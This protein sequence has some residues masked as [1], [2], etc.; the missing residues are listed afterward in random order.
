MLRPLGKRDAVAAVIIFVLTVA[1]TYLTF[2][3]RVTYWNETELKLLRQQVESMR[4]VYVSDR[5][6]LR[7]EL[8]EVERTL[9][10]QPSATTTIIRRP[11]VVEQWQINRDKELRDR[12]VQLERWRY[13]MER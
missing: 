5:T 6:T 11:S 10:S 13:R 3:V 1:C 7:A 9:Y 2:R 4:Q 8:D 12:V